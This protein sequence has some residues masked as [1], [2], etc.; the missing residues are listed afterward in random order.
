MRVACR[1]SLLFCLLPALP[2]AYP[3]ELRWASLG[4]LR[5]ENGQV[6]QDCRVG[7]RT[8]GQL[9]ASKSN[10]I[11][12]PT[13]FGGKTEDLERLVGPGKLLNPEGYFLILV[14]ALGNGVSSSPSNSQRQPGAAFPEF[15][16]GD[17]VRAEYRLATEVL[18]LKKLKAVMGISMGGMQTFEWVVAYPDFVE[19]AIPIVGT[20]QQT[21][22]DLLLWNTELRLIEQATR[23]SCA[24]PQVMEHVALIHRLALST[25]ENFVR[26]VSRAAFDQ[27]LRQVVEGYRNRDPYDWASQL[28]AMIRHDIARLHGGSL[29]KAAAAVKAR[30]LVIVATQDHMV[31]PLPAIR[32]AGFV[33]AP[34]VRLE[35]DCG[36]LATGCEQAKVAAAIARFLSE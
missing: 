12:W 25:P 29:E 10:A 27:Y 31:N 16:I 30:M 19:K 32:F 11:L 33:G 6:I 21:S 14:D 13:W 20:P 22:Y 28:R 1:V 9:D 8:Y 35:G 17:M 4:D 34:V 24:W 36:H 7:Y 23:C 18:G 3:A 15:G 5:L 26:E 2:A